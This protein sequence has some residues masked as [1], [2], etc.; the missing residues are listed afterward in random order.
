M[1]TVSCYAYNFPEEKKNKL[2]YRDCKLCGESIILIKTCQQS[3][4]TAV[5]YIMSSQDIMTLWKHILYPADA[6]VSLF[7]RK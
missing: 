3:S 1:G 6:Q 5:I 2:V 4:V 7:I